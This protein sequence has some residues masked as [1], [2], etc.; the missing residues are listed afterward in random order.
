M[1]FTSATLGFFSLLV[2]RLLHAHAIVEHCEIIELHCV[3]PRRRG[4]FAMNDDNALCRIRVSF[5]TMI[6][7]GLESVCHIGGRV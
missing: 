2:M 1:N 3:V 4:P 5:Y 6:E 7:K